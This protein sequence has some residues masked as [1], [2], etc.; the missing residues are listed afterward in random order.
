MLTLKNCQTS[1]TIGNVGT[2]LWPPMTTK[3]TI[4]THL[5]YEELTPLEY[6]C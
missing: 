1:R 4:N 2:Y 6:L 3:E 5:I